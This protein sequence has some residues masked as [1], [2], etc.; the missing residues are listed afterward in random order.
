MKALFKKE[1]KENF[2]KFIIESTLLIGIAFSLIPYGYRLTMNLNPEV[3][4]EI[5]RMG[6][7]GGELSS[8][9]PKLK[10]LNFFIY[11]QWF[12]KNL[13][14]MALLFAV[15]NSAG[16]I[17]GET[18]RKTGIFLFSRPVSRNKILF[19]KLFVILSYTLIPIVISTYVLLLL[20]RNIPQQVNVA[21]INKLLLQSVIATSVAVLITAI[22]SVII[23]DR[24]KVGLSAIGII[25]G[26][27]LIG[28]VSKTMNWISFTSLYLGKFSIYTPVGI[29]LCVAFTLIAFALL[30]RKEF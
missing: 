1:A 28:S 2:V 8:M 19:V 6:K 22:I 13:F 17:A 24:V 4:K 26:T 9:L 30:A 12:G 21:M 15:V 23:S 3:F 16:I 5:I 7:I 25:I 29:I 10:D 27:I 11:S 14:E 18:E 20:A